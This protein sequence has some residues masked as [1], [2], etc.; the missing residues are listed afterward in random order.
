MRTSHLVALGAVLV[1]GAGCDP[2]KFTEKPG[3]QLPQSG[4]AGSTGLPAE[5][6]AGS[7]TPTSGGAAGQGAAGTTGAAGS[8]PTPPPPGCGNAVVDPGEA[9]DDGNTMD[10]DGCSADCSKAETSSLWYADADGDMFGA[11]NAMPEAAY[12]KP[13]GKV[14]NNADC[15]DSDA[16]TN[17][18]VVDICG[19]V[20]DQDCSGADRP[21]G[22]A[23]LVVGVTAPLPLQDDAISMRL[24]RL[25]YT[26]TPIS[27][28]EVTEASA[29]GKAVVV[30]S[31]SVTSTEVNTKL[32]NVAVPLVTY[33]P[34]LYDDLGMATSPGGQEA[35]TQQ[36]QVVLP[37]HPLAAGVP[38]GTS[39]VYVQPLSIGYAL[40]PAPAA[41]IIAKV[42]LNAAIFAYETGAAMTAINAPA[43]RVGLF[44]GG[45]AGDDL[46]ADG[47]R[48]FDAAVHWAAGNR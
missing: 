2:G 24:V 30:I 11:T 6:S 36:L 14:Q 44:I 43:R 45:G 32:T 48:F 41:T 23:L 37:M 16:M 7:G 46:S 17:P 35:D 38:F 26:V 8:T 1:L 39:A 9:C 42:G 12:C 21:C 40:D 34:A 28:L 47:G 31:E 4:V 18:G 20:I 29:T 27:A 3:D 19:D 5:G 33:E 15:L 25:G 10:C 13:M 22:E